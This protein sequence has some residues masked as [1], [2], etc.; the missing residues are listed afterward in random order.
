MVDDWQSMTLS[1]LNNPWIYGL[2]LILLL[3]ILGRKLRKR[4]KKRISVKPDRRVLEWARSLDR[5]ERALKRQGF[6][7]QPGETVGAFLARVE[8]ITNGRE[9]ANA[10]EALREYEKRR[11]R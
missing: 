7:R 9:S 11:W 6:V 1:V 8:N 2:P 5:A 4:I 10:V 3:A